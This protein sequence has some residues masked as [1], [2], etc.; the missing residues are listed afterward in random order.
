MCLLQHRPKV[1]TSIIWF[2]YPPLTNV[3]NKNGRFF[4]GQLPA[5]GI[6]GQHSSNESSLKAADITKHFEPCRQPFPSKA[7]PPAD[8]ARKAST[9]PQQLLPFHASASLCARGRKVLWLTETWLS[10][11]GTSIPGHQLLL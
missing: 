1:F 9:N 5:W 11:Y 7:C 4:F 3:F 2:F 8:A 10:A 6:F